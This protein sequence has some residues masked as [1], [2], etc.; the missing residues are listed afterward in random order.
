VVRVVDLAHTLYHRL[1]ACSS[2]TRVIGKVIVESSP[3]PFLAL[4]GSH[5]FSAALAPI[6]CD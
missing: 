6:E 2:V 1:Q 3:V 5:Q 4:A